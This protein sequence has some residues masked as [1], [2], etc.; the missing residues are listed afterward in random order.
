VKRRSTPRLEEFERLYRQRYPRFL[1]VAEGLTGNVDSARD[2]VQE[3]FARA[4][5]ARHDYRGDG[6]LENWVWSC[7]VNAARQARLREELPL[8]EELADG[9][10]PADVGSTELLRSL[11]ERQRLV[12][13]L[14]HYADLDYAAMADVL[15]IAVGTVGAT[16]NK[17]HAALRRRL[18]EVPR[19]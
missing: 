5:R 19:P 15:G 3:G 11:P 1:R 2:A 10:A 12:V 14:R 7:V 18:E 17:A 8:S 13:F 6:P 9:R 16:L 4:I